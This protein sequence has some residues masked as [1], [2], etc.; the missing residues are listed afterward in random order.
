METTTWP[1]RA[2]YDARGDC[3]YIRFSDEQ[4]VHHTQRVYMAP[5]D[6]SGS[7]VI[8]FNEGGEILSLEVRGAAKVLPSLVKRFREGDDS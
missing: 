7:L 6:L 1:L 8:G 4:P 5:C 2:S 3:G